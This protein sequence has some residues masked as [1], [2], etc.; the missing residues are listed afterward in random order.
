MSEE[1]PQPEQQH[2]PEQEQGKSSYQ[3]DMSERKE[4]SNQRTLE[5]IARERE[6]MDK[7]Q[8]FGFF[9][10]PYPSTVGDQAYSRNREFEHH[11][12]VDRKVITEKRGIYTQPVKKG[13]GPDV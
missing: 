10:I 13:K 8:R 7:V 3:E 1:S 9:S 11:Q 2:P 5:K 6:E 12:V 4:Q